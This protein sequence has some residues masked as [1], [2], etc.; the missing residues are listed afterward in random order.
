MHCLLR[1]VSVA[2]GSIA[3]CWS[4]HASPQC[5]DWQSGFHLD[6]A[7]GRVFATAV[8]DDGSG[9]ALYVGGDFGRAGSVAAPGIAKWNGSTWSAVGTA[10]VYGVHALAV[11]DDGTGPALFVGGTFS[12]FPGGFS[13]HIAKWDGTS[14]TTV[15][16]GL[17]SAVETFAVFDD[18]SGAA[19]FAG[20]VFT[21]TGGVP[22][23]WIG[24]WNGSSWASLG[25]GV[26]GP[27]ESLCVFDDGTGSALYV[28][29]SFNFAAGIPVN[30]VARFDGTAWSALG[31]GMAGGGAVFA[32][33]VYDAGTGPR[34]YAG[35]NFTHAGG[36][37]ASRIASWDGSA[38]SALSPPITG[39]GEVQALAVFD[40]GS[41]PAL[42]LGGHFNLGG[43][44]C[45]AKW[46]GT[47]W[48]SVPGG[49]IFDID[50]LC[51]FDDGS[52]P[53]LFAG[54]DFEKAGGNVPAN[55]LA[56]WR[57]PVWKSVGAGNG[58]GP[59]ESSSPLIQSMAV[60]GQGATSALFA[61]GTFTDAGG[62]STN[63]AARW[64]GSSW[65]ALPADSNL[66]VFS[67]SA[68]DDGTGPAA[69][70]CG[71]FTTINGA[72]VK[73][74]AKWNG[75]G[76]DAL[77]S[78]MDGVVNTSASGNIGSGPALFVGGSFTNAG[79]VSAN[80][81]AQWNGSTWASMGSGMIHPVH[82]MCLFDDGS[83]TTL[84][85]ASY[86]LSGSV[87]V[88]T[89]SKWIGSTWL[90]LGD[91]IGAYPPV[92]ALCVFHD[93]AG[94][95]LCVGGSISNN[96]MTWNG[97][98]WGTLGGGPGGSV[99]ALVEYD[100][101]TGGGSSLYASTHT[102]AALEHTIRRWDGAAWSTVASVQVPTGGAVQSFTVFDDHT[103][104]GPTLYAGGLFGAVNGVV[105]NSIAALRGCGHPGEPICFGDGS[106]SACP[107][108]NNGA[109]SH[110]CDNSANTGGAKLDSAGWTSLAFDSLVLTSSGELPSVLS[111]FLQGTAQIAPAIF[112]DGL[113][114]A[115]GNLK[116]LYS[117]N[118]SGGSVSAPG[119]GDA[120]ISARSLALGDA[121]AIGASRVYQVY[122]RDP[123]LAFCAAPPGDAWNVSSALRIDWLP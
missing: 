63:G 24:K 99:D 120:S 102:T 117:K 13:E 119:S 66:D 56:A 17:N 6:G 87:G 36:I 101:G 18:G 72:S 43:Y 29:G 118:A 110:G 37:P 80:R 89:I 48:L 26:D 86:Y 69:Y 1:N 79:G 76:W 2:L 107:C 97:S 94:P 93:A 27:V 84:Y 16:A 83:G 20:G 112:G 22:L 75:N 92:S 38:W 78:G 70:F 34:L 57:S 85:A 51:A 115:G 7:S 55:N 96:V 52:G 54:G 23:Q 46:D 88:A 59:G 113:R 10:R 15:G 5:P 77:G 41:G 33:H 32:L 100:D 64:D 60:V 21:N 109:T 111:I 61:G 123:N 71:G 28:G 108:A 81:A 8:F 116:R 68:F 62:S 39:G 98:T 58:V 74:V 49:Q 40:D 67:V 3:L 12:T 106:G 90:S 47:A 35:G 121:I 91:F 65:L 104:A 4:A 82:E 103:G 45:F 30:D 95:V 105:S 50:A 42:F 19:L 11:F 73:H 53:V 31:S 122:Y 114:C 14:W 9:P 44:Q 25:V